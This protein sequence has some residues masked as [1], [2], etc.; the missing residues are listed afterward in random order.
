MGLPQSST[1]PRSCCQRLI[2][3]L[4]IPTRTFLFPIGW[5]GQGH[6]E[7]V[8]GPGVRTQAIHGPFAIDTVA[9]AVDFVRTQ[10]IRGPFV[11]DTVASAVDLVGFSDQYLVDVLG[12]FPGL[13]CVCLVHRIEQSLC[14]VSPVRG[15]Q[16]GCVDPFFMGRTHFKVLAFELGSMTRSARYV[17]CRPAV[18]TGD[19][20]D[21]VGQQFAPLSPLFRCDGHGVA[22]RWTAV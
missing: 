17:R 5:R 1:E 14:H 15:H 10:A 4:L 8:G 16:E 7:P 12:R 18:G 21:L 3:S 9:P 20:Q 11:V 6:P 22:S 13:P 19:S 2:S